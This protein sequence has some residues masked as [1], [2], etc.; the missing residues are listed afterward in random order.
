MQNEFHNESIILSGIFSNI[1]LLV[2]TPEY[3]IF[4]FDYMK[5]IKSHNSNM[6]PIKGFNFMFMDMSVMSIF[7]E[8]NF[9]KQ[10]SSTFS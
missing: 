3:V 6:H 5:D 7:M 10:L 1:F 4:L 8:S 2:S 9:K